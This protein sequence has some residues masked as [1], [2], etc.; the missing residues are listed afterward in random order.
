MADD[1]FQGGWHFL[2]GGISG[3]QGIRFADEDLENYAYDF[4]DDVLNIDGDC[5]TMIQLQPG[6]EC[7][8][9][10]HCIIPPALWRDVVDREVK[11]G[12]Y[13]Y[14]QGASWQGGI[15]TYNSIRDWVASSVEYIEA[16][17][18]RGEKVDDGDGDG[19]EEEEE[20][21][22]GED[23]EEEGG[24]E[25]EGSNEEREAE[26]ITV[27]AMTDQG[28]NQEAAGEPLSDWEILSPQPDEEHMT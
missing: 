11:D 8:G 21:E 23:E 16:M 20:E 24:E 26:E 19:D 4:G 18:E 13:R 5:R 9:F 14:W 10:S 17:I 2:D 6:T 7:D 1:S 25:S 12:E 3:V 15:S 28:D 27:P 22:E